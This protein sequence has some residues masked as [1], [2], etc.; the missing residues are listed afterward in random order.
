MKVITHI[1]KDVQPL[2]VLLS[3]GIFLIDLKLPLGIGIWIFYLVPLFL[4]AIQYNPMLPL[5]AA[6][7]NTALTTVGFLY[8]PIGVAADI[9]LLNRGFGVALIWLIAFVERQLILARIQIE[10]ENWLNSGAAKFYEASRNRKSLA[11]LAEHFLDAV[12]PYLNAQVGAFY[13]VSD[14]GQLNLEGTFAVLP[15][16]LPRTLRMGEGLIGQ[17]SLSQ[18][19]LRL[20][21][22]PENYLNISSATGATRPRSILVVPLLADGQTRAVLELGFIQN[23]SPLV[24]ELL[25][26]VAES[27]AMSVQSIQ[28][29]RRLEALLTE[30]Q[31]QSEELT[32]QQEELE[33]ANTD[34]EHRGHELQVQQEELAQSNEEL[35]EQRQR[36][37][38]QNERL[39][40]N[41]EQLLLAKRDVEEKGEALATAN[42]YKSEFLA[43]M[44]HELR[45]PL[46][47]ILI[48]AK[49][50]SEYRGTFASEQAE[51]AQTI[52]S[53]STDLLN[54]ISDI[55]DLSKV[56]A[57]KLEIVQTDV[58]IPR[59]LE[60]VTR[61]LLPLLETK[62]LRFSARVMDEKLAVLATDKSRLEQI[63][64][65]FLSNAIKF[66]AKG[67][68]ELTVDRPAADFVSNNPR[69]ANRDKVIA[70]SVK[71]S[72]IGIPVAKQKA[73][74]E[75]FQQVDGSISRR[76]GG[77]GL[78][79]TISRE[80]AALL[81]GEIR[82][83]SGEGEG[84]T[85]TVYLP[86]EGVGKT[87]Q[88][89][90]VVERAVPVPVPVPKVV[91]SEEKPTS[92][93]PRLINDDRDSL[94]SQDKRIAIIEDDLN[95]A[96]IL[97]D[98][99]RA[100]GFKAIASTDGESGL[101]DVQRFLPHAILL[102]IRLPGMSGLDVLN[103]LKRDPKTR[104]IPVEVLSVEER[105]REVRRLGAVDF[106]SKP[107]TKEKLDEVMGE[108]SRLIHCE[109]KHVLIIEDDAA[110][111]K[112]LELLVG[113]GIVKSKSV[114][115]GAHALEAMREVR[116]D[117][118]ILDLHLPDM[119]GFDLLDTI[120]N[121]EELCCPP[122]IVYTG[123]DLSRE[124]EER[125]Q[126]FSDSIIIKGAK[127]PE[128]LLSEVTLFLHR[129]EDDL[130]EDQK[131]ILASMRH[132]EDIFEGKKILVADD[133]M[134]NI[135]ALRQALRN[136]GLELLVAKN[137]REAVEALQGN[138]DTALVLMDIMMP[139]MDGFEAMGA[140]REDKRFKR[141]P[142]IALTAKAMKG[143]RERCLEAGASDYLP[144][145]LEVDSLLSLLRIW[146]S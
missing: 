81:G 5:Y 28:T 84:S 54:L 113:N 83:K 122:V 77:T 55:L 52:H 59:I 102:D 127:S 51:M 49:L 125:L 27:I 115:T 132:R 57:G 21:E 78:G 38:E 130:P 131:K 15:E 25:A 1:R 119:N 138:P 26:Q 60:D 118:I 9:A 31:R 92:S 44:S 101:A 24:E 67:S 58:A 85:F 100:N 140:I 35:E 53:A 33:A 87:L 71:D 63:L 91:S 14:T 45:T 72:G 42:R 48:L 43:N 39:I 106:I 129:V 4:C 10:N 137:G 90:L 111:R 17:A 121:D 32:A 20:P 18:R 82:L 110:E 126:E 109:A 64:K 61:P 13:A 74:F 22:V 145:P 142:I 143:D 120:K 134:R 112:S 97:I 46:N 69:L 19:P 124:E 108:L 16:K 7:I 89:R 114:A 30:T 95:F 88:T 29:R 136:R 34:L 128:R 3:L 80:L 86:E 68:I 8:S 141:L 93:A 79:L 103:R 105:Q 41:N 133:D 117:C 36:L 76:Y 99:C 62:K 6:G 50:L 66:T 116:Y 135:F 12:A 56:E 123:K 75:A 37:E 70:F 2:I 107:L 23:P 146:L 47:S 65:N 73:I 94:A 104:H 144:K 98:H 11:D 139:E 40:R 96:K